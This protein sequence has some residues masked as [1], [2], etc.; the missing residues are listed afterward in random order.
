MGHSLKY[1]NNRPPAI[2]LCDD[3][4]AIRLILSAQLTARGYITYEA[5]T[6]DEIL[7]AVPV[8]RPEVIILRSRLA[9]Y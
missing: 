2:L 5:S 9:G 8:F 4:E 1:W 7:R 3:E 6:G